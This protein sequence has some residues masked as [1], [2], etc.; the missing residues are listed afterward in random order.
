MPHYAI[1]AVNPDYAPALREAVRMGRTLCSDACADNPVLNSALKELSKSGVWFSSRNHT[2]GEEHAGD[3]LVYIGSSPTTWERILPSL[4]ATGI[5]VSGVISPHRPLVIDVP[6]ESSDQLVRFLPD[7]IQEFP[8][9]VSPPLLACLANY[10]NSLLQ[11][12]YAALRPRQTAHSQI[13]PAL[14]PEPLN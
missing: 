5:F 2:V 11:Q 1:V 14:S 13:A 10:A 8:G 4:A 7:W 9:E 3:F 6:H 12:T